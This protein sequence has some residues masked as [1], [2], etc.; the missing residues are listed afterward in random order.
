MPNVLSSNLTLT[1]HLS[2]LL[3]FIGHGGWT[4]WGGWHG[5]GSCSKSCGGGRKLRTKYRGCTNPSPYCGGRVCSGIRY[6]TQSSS[7]NTHCCKRKTNIQI[8]DSFFNIMHVT[9]GII[10]FLIYR[11]CPRIYEHPSY[12]CI[13]TPV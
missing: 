4:G 12:G 7:C 13:H 3:H 2:Y 6:T 9:I 5:W 8:T 11:G 1:A 10:L